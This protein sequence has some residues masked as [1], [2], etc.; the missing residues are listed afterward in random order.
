MRAATLG[1][2][3]SVVQGRRQQRVS[4]S[5][6]RL[7]AHDRHVGIGS[8]LKGGP[9]QSLFD[10]LRSC[11]TVSRRRGDQQ[12][13]I[14]RPAAAARPG[15]RE[16]RP[17]SAEQE[18]RDPAR[19]GATRRPDRSACIARAISRAR[20]GFPPLAWATPALNGGVQRGPRRFRS[21]WPMAQSAS[22]GSG[23]SRRGSARQWIRSPPAPGSGRVAAT[24]LIWRGPAGTRRSAK[25]RLPTL[26]WS[27]HCRS[28]RMSATGPDSMS[29][30][31]NPRIASGTARALTSRPS[32]SARCRATARARRCGPGR[33]MSAPSGS[34]P[35]ELG[36]RGKRQSPIELGRRNREY[37]AAADLG[38]LRGGPQHAA[39]PGTRI[40]G[41]D[42]ASAADQD[43]VHD[44][45]SDSSRPN[46][47]NAADTSFIWSS[48]SDRIR[49]DRGSWPPGRG[50]SLM[51]GP[52]PP[53]GCS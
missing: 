49:L 7:G 46:S 23:N 9:Q 15:C 34:W 12:E 27:S 25:P 36:Q 33:P 52:A 22:G 16:A 51:P 18:R 11:V 44:P 6:H 53:A 48:S 13:D 31:S 43:V 26:A 24:T 1:R 41:D 30:V 45:Q 19:L 42:H 2:S 21:S 40:T 50:V 17:G 32:G 10:D 35:I 3:S 14:A 5:H 20:N 38:Q 39:L 47:P 29:W 28:S 8:R 37:P 4:E